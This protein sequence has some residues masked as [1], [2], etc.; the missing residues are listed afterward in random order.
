V[1]FASKC[2]Q[3]DEIYRQRLQLFEKKSL[4]DIL[5]YLKVDKDLAKLAR[6]TQFALILDDFRRFKEKFCP[7]EML[8]QITTNFQRL[9]VAKVEV[10]GARFAICADHLITLTL[11]Q[12][13]VNQIPQLG[14]ELA[15]IETLLGK[16][17]EKIMHQQSGYCFTCLK[18]TYS[19][20]TSDAFLT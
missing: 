4:D 7:F 3:K 20:L 12:V 18:A 2:S 8:N 9:E 15:M 14:A 6:S 10:L 19:H 11:I 13:L 16:D 1:L 5:T 17:M